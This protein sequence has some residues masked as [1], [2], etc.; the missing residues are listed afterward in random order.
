MAITVTKVSGPYYQAGRG[1]GYTLSVLLDS[2]FTAGGEVL[3]IRTYLG[4][5]YE[6]SA[7]GTDAIADNTWRFDITGPGRAV[8]T[9]ASN[10]LITA[11]HGSGADAV[12]NP[13][14]AE[15]L[16]TVGALI[17]QIWGKKA[18]TSSWS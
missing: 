6:G 2:S 7:Q 10:V 17:I 12:D 5:L 1:T 13:A 18:L 15:D 16:S 9:G 14:D 8:A 4:Y 11:H 3:D